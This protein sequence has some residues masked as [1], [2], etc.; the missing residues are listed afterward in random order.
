MTHL[1]CDLDGVLV[2]FEGG[3]LRT[4]GHGHMDVK[5]KVMWANIDAGGTEYWSALPPLPDYMVL[6]NYIIPYRPTILTGC[7]GFTELSKSH[8]NAKKGKKWW[9]INNLPQDS[10]YGFIACFSKHKPTFMT[11]PGDIL[12]DDNEK[13]GMLWHAAGGV[14]VHHTTAADTIMKLEQLGI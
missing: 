1:F 11:G 10:E 14:F 13:I 6:W 2:D 8:Q 9:G 4:F 12:I 3:Y 7:P 5:K